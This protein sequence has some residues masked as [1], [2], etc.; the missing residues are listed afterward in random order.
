[1]IIN[2]GREQI[3]KEN[4]SPLRMSKNKVFLVNLQKN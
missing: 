2:N 4:H 1:M 3:S